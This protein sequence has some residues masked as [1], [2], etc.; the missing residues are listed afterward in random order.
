MSCKYFSFFNL[1][2][3]GLIY[4]SCLIFHNILFLSSCKVFTS[5]ILTRSD[6][7]CIKYWTIYDL[8]SPQ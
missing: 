3:K 1:L 5:H 7:G 2:I 8:Y 6:N 4:R